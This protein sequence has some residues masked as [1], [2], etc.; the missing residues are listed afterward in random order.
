MITTITV[1]KLQK[2][3]SREEAQSIFLSTAPK[4]QN[5]PGLVRK[6]Y[7]LSQN[8]NTVGG[9]YLWNSRAEAESMYTESW[10]D[11]V[12]EKYGC[13]PSVTY[14]ETPVV[15]DNLTNEILSDD[16]AGV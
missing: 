11:Y 13:D 12:R 2:P 6:C 15:V 4:Y 14:F 9:I 16:Q 10:R 8:G 5:V 1:F 7:I 3:I